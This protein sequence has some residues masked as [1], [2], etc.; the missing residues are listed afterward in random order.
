ME[1]ISEKI[2][3]NL[4]LFNKLC[5]IV[6]VV[7]CVNRKAKVI[8]QK[9]EEKYYETCYEYWK[10]DSCCSNCISMRALEEKDTFVKLE[11]N[12]ERVV[13]VIA[14]PVTLGEEIYVVEM[15]K[16]ITSLGEFQGFGD[17]CSDN[18]RE[19]INCINEKILKDELTGLYNRRCVKER[20]F[21]DLK[22][23]EEKGAEMSIVVADIDKFKKINNI[24]GYPAGDKIL[25]DIAE[26][27]SKTIVNDLSWAAR[28]DNGE[29]LIVFKNVDIKGVY[30]TAEKIR[31]AIEK[32]TF[33]YGEDKI[34]VT[35]SF[36]IYRVES[37][38]DNVEKILE[39]ADKSLNEVKKRK[40]NTTFI[41]IDHKSDSN[42]HVKLMEQIEEL[43]EILNEIS[44]TIDD[45][46]DYK[47]RQ[48]MSE[49]LDNLIVEYMNRTRN[50]RTD[51]TIC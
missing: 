17:N 27:I 2:G 8:S 36:G 3:E 16:D 10:R 15:L 4:S 23:C 1:D 11:Y 42:N 47:Q 32:N 22:E 26:F 46:G 13:I 7:D 33:V 50:T 14:V 25:K 12:D 30:N 6:R 44:C 31:R 39:N 48:I 38:I 18:M 9:N 24:Y 21:L 37:G 43:R 51:D 45:T 20:L 35:A 19:L 5:D 34:K 40:R 29:F 49:Q 28:Y 41:N